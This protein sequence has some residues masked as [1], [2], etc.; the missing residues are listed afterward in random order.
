MKEE[1]A[2]LETQIKKPRPGTCRAQA[3][4]THAKFGFCPGLGINFCHPVR[5]RVASNPDRTRGF[6][7]PTRY[8]LRYWNVGQVFKSSKSRPLESSETC[9]VVHTENTRLH[10][11][12][13]EVELAWDYWVYWLDFVGCQ[14]SMKSTLDYIYLLANGVI[15]SKS[16][17]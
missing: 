15:S 7:K 10:A 17:K 5:S 16:A 3:W 4:T 2:G 9:L 11:H 14:D 6:A 8:Y 1:F 12:I 13:S